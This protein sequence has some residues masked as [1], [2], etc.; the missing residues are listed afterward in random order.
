MPQVVLFEVVLYFYTYKQLY[1]FSFL[2]FDNLAIVS[3]TTLLFTVS[4]NA[5]R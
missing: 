2:S 4:D 1:V 5:A 3:R